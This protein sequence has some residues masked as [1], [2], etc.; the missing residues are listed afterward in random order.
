MI[1]LRIDGQRCDMGSL[2]TI[3]IGFDIASLTKVEGEREGRYI[4][5]ELP[6]SPANDALFG[7]S[8]D[9]YATNRFNTEHHIAIVEKDGVQIFGGT[10]YLLSTTVKDSFC[11]KYTIR[12]KEGGAEWIDS[13]VRR[14]LSDLEIPFTGR[15]NL[16]T[17][18]SSWEGEQSV[19]FLPVYRGNFQPHYSS[20]SVIPV[21]HILLT[22]DYHPFISV[23]DMVKAIF[24]DTDYTLCS[25]F[26]DSDFGRSLYMSGDYARTT[27]TAAKEK[28]DFFARRAAVG[29]STADFL[30]RVYASNA[31]AAH[32]IGPIV[33]T[34]DPNATDSEGKEM[35][36]T[37]S[38]N[39]SFS[40]NGVGNICFTPKIS[41][42]AGFMLHLEYTTDYKIL[43]RDRLTGFDVV[44]G[45]NGERVEVMLA[46]TCKDFRGEISTNTQYR[47]VVF[48]H[49]EGREYML[50]AKHPNNM[51]SVLGSWSSR[52]E[53]IT[54]PSISIS[55]LSLL[56]RDSDESES[57][58]PYNGDW[59]LYA[60]YVEESG[61]MDVE[62]D[63]RI[64]PQDVAAGET[65]VLDK[66][67]FGGAEPGMTLTI[68]T[69]TSLRPYF[70]T[71]PGYNAPLDFGDIA[72]RNITQGELLTALGEM[73]NLAF[74]TDR[75]RKEVHIEPL[76]ELYERGDEVDWSNRVDVVGGVE[77]ADTGVGLPQNIELKYLDTDRASHAFNLENE[78]ELG[79][80][81]LR[82]PLYGTKE[83]TR[84]LGNGLFTTT[85]NTTDVIGCAPSA[86]IM[87]VGDMGQEE[88]GLDV[89][90]T[91]RIVCYKG[92][93]SL[94]EG[95]SWGAAVARLNSY[96]YAAFLDDEGVN[97]CF[98]NRNGT[99]GLHT[100][101]L[102]MLQRQCEG[103]TITLNL[104][105]TTL[106]IATLFTADGVLPSLRSR[107]RFKIQGESSL[108]RLAKVER[109]DTE[110][111]VV[112]CSFERELCE[113]E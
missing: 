101:Y 106:E 27:N 10:V 96:P 21:E 5:L 67:W 41:V 95:E 32:T 50:S 113:R 79:R 74:Y 61:R 63:F 100:R 81:T 105:L 99:D 36:D 17:I 69:A 82:N 29:E 53:L 54:T 107:F 39:G 2:P 70:T 9:I 59:A 77:V 16:A 91:P 42:K 6:C 84:T 60:G 58:Y 80:W 65:L 89:A 97:L 75:N 86:S 72:P 15:L 47:A 76:E 102:P 52:S 34:A 14:K 38:L 68:G 55:T 11:G 109:W 45:L 35:S 24:A 104:Y 4:E 112:R 19:R 7:T 108:F 25:N 98:E 46:N 111:S 37:F 31:F 64:A 83:T 78:T 92:M 26:F 3:P 13:A 30:G 56:Y 62:M 94:P 18:A 110:S 28:C 49:T 103:Q 90:F 33:D 12:I 1:T 23:A 48:D 85:L 20:S 66:F 43:S 73:F 87:Q 8:R 51:H 57:W 88:L 40:K 93:R 22:D 71:V 44:E